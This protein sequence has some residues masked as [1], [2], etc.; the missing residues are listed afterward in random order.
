MQAIEDLIGQTP[1]ACLY[2][3]TSPDG[4]IGIVENRNLWATDYRHLNDRQEYRFGAKLLLQELDR[5][6]VNEDVRRVFFDLVQFRQSGCFVLS[7]SEHG[8]RLSQW[9]AY[10]AGGSGFS[11]GFQ[12]ESDFFKLAKREAFHL[13]RCEYDPK[14]QR[15]LCSELVSSFIEHRIEIE[16]APWSDGDPFSALKNL[17]EPYNWTFRLAIVLA[18]LKH[19]G[20]E[21][22]REWRLVSQHTQRLLP[23]VSFRTGRFGVTPFFKLSLSEGQRTPKGLAWDS[24]LQLDDVVIGP[25]PNRR[26]SRTALEMLLLKNRT[27]ARDIRHSKTPLRQ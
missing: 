27:L 18:S 20:F 3:Y 8:D 19:R 13:V 21:E 26:A 10:C 16:R 4:M 1:G 11:L 25:T 12:Q 14:R 6:K 22:E 24:I 23:R 17:F 9:R 2:H 5:R 7:F 15:T